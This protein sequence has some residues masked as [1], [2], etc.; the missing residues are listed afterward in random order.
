MAQVE[1]CR[2]VSKLFKLFPVWAK[3]HNILDNNDGG[4]GE[5]KWV[6]VKI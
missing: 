3:D 1:M 4:G 6:G 5:K 2:S